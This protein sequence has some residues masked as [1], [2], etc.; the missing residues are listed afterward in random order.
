MRKYLI[1]AAVLLMAACTKEGDTIYMPDPTEEQASNAPIVTVIYGDNSLGD[2]SYCDMIYEGVERTA[3]ELGLR[4]MQLSPQSTEEGLQYLEL[5]MRQMETAQDSVH[6]LFIVTSPVYDEYLRTNSNRLAKNANADLLYLE[7]RTPLP[8]KGSTLFLPYYG[9]MFEA[10]AMMPAL[11]ARVMLIGAN[12]R[13][14]AIID[15]IQGFSDGWN[16]NMTSVTGKKKKYLATTYLDETGEGGYVVADTTAMRMIK[17]WINDDIY[18]IVPI[19]GGA[20]NTFW[21][22]NEIELG[23]LFIMGIDKEYH[24][25]RSH[26]SVVKH[27]DQA[28]D[29]CIRQWLSGEGMPK[30]QS[31]GLA[32]GYTDVIRTFLDYSEQ[33]WEEALD[34]L[35]E[36]KLK[37]IHETALRKEEEYEKK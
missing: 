9:A 4:T 13:E 1:M 28:I 35:N 7:T 27:I 30:H 19:C 36:Q 21:R 32:S 14:Q 6:R 31:L 10:G 12:R 26:L 23:S 3:Q 25:P 24:T 2:R 16:A 8:G 37:E 33:Y 29:R 34:E 5:M 11:G 22:M 20:F 17:Q 18:D 15:A